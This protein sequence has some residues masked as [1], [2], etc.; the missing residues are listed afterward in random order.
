VSDDWRDAIRVAGAEAATRPRHRIVRG[1]RLAAITLV[2]ILLA[3]GVPRPT[4]AAD[5]PVR[6]ALTPVGQAGSF[7]D[8]VMKP[9]ETR[10]LKVD[11]LN[12]GATG[13]AVRTYAADVYTIVNGGFGGRVRDEPQ[14]GTTRW[15][16]YRTGVLQLA[17]R[18]S[19]RRVFSVAV[20][21][22]ATPGE[23]ITSLI[24]ENDQPIAGGGTVALDQIVRQAVAVVVTV[25]GPRSPALVIG[26]ASYGLVASGS[27]V[28]VALTNSGNVRLKPIV[29]F[30]LFDALGTQVG[31]A[32]VPM[33]TFYART[34]TTIEVPL[35][36]PLAPGAYT[37]RLTLDDA[38]QGAR[39]D[40]AGIAFV[41]TAPAPAPATGTG[42]G[43][44]ETIQAL[45]DGRMTPLAWGLVVL[46]LVLLWALGG[47][48]AL[49]LRRRR[50]TATP[51]A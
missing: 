19:V 42:F 10:S 15:L 8:L 41:V 13:L 4:L 1:A 23:Y 25:P 32:T 27:V 12:A 5:I 35:A 33:D 11:I 51:G 18:A 9:G 49:F 31:Q 22:D 2:G 29:T 7:F 48:I 21:A 20:P 36:A 47:T 44:T 50:R 39:A 16:D 3:I 46:G 34:V 40:R 24:L 45:G 28:S 26:E 30:S 38:A 6:L 37:V 14:T 43:L 17:A